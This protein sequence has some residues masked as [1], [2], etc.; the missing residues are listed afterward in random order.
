MKAPVEGYE[1]P[2]HRAVWERPM[3][4]GAPRLWSGVWGGLCIYPTLLALNKVGFHG[5][6]FVVALW[7]VGQSVLF[8]LTRWDQAFD[9]VGLAQLFRRYKTFYNAG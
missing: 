3:S 4:M 1:A 6:L 8:G 9:E 2:I 5:A 7:M